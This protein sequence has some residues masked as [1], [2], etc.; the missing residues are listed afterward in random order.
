MNRCCVQLIFLVENNIVF[1]MECR[2]NDLVRKKN[3]PKWSQIFALIKHWSEI[4]N[5]TLSQMVIYSE[6]VRD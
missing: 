4:E 6:P 5:P 1:T 2:I 3:N